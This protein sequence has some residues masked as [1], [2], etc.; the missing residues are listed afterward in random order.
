MSTSPNRRPAG[1]P[2]GGQFAPSSHA[3]SSASLAAPRER[4]PYPDF[5]PEER[6]EWSSAGFSRREATAWRLFT[7][8]SDPISPAEAREWADRFIVVEASRWRTQRF[9]P[10]EADRWSNAGFAP[11]VP[12]PDSAGSWRAAA[13]AP[14]MAR[15]W[16]KVGFGAKSARE[17]FDAGFGT[18]TARCW[19]NAG[20]EPSE[21]A[22][23]MSEARQELMVSW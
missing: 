3:E 13:F 15:A 16:R 6:Q 21:A 1:T 4:R 9:T 17:W 5:T 11:D 2:A 7:N 12:G 18:I 8:S 19:S 14:D 23:A 10:D 20:F 22:K